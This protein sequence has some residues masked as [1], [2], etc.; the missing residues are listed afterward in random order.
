[1]YLL[2]G[3]HEVLNLQGQYQFT[4]RG[5]V[6][7]FKSIDRREN[8]FSPTGKYGKILR[9]EMNV[10]VTVNDSLFVHAG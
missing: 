2:L 6:R 1:M 10:T 7:S 8:A 4:S 9:G 5:D 3:N